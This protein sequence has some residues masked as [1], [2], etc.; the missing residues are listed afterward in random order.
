MADI[1]RDAW[2]A[3]D[4]R[5]ARA[6]VSDG[7]FS[8]FQVQLALM[9]QENR[10]NVMGDASVLSADH[11][12]G[13]ER[14]AARRRARAPDGAGARHRGAG[15]RA[16]DRDPPRARA[17]ARSS[18]TRRS[19]RSC[20]APARRP[21]PR[22]SRSGA[23]A[24]RAARRSTAARSSSAATAARSSAR[25]STTGCSRRSRSS[26]S[27]SPTRVARDVGLD[28]LRRGDPGVAREV[29]ED[30][31]SYVFWKWVEAGR[32]E[33]GLAAAQVRVAAPCWRAPERSLRR[34]AARATSRWA[35]RTSS[36][37]SSTGGRVRSRL[38]RD[39]LVGALRRRP[40]PT[41]V[42]DGDAPGAA[43]GRRR[44]CR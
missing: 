6:F 20:G 10:R 14:R 23:R 42:P 24:R 43:V 17:R 37:A 8:R 22:A 40:A 18:R 12:G 5:P 13:R 27:G 34:R 41:P 19:G 21:S 39:P 32:A 28:A 30:R 9:R 33:R 35:A 31:A 1:L 11:R 15:R 3:G 44:S 25:G 38:R 2:C 36:H 29:L 26:R 7:V 16:D 4:M